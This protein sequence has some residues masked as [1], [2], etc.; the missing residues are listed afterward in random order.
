[1]VL[2]QALAF[3]IFL[4]DYNGAAYTTLHSDMYRWCVCVIHTHKK[5]TYR[6]WL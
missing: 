6:L 1:M 2:Y 4:V 3:H 5:V